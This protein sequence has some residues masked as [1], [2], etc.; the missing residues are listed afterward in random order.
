MNATGTH[1]TKRGE[2]ARAKNKCLSEIP[3]EFSVQIKKWSS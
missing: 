2:D 3:D 1:D